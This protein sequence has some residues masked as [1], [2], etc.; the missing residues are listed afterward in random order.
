MNFKSFPLSRKLFFIDATGAVVSAIA[1]GMILPAFQSYIGLPVGTLYQLAVPAVLFALYSGS[2][3][4]RNLQHPG[5]WL[6]GIGL[7]NL[8]YVFYTGYFLFQNQSQVQ[9]LG[10]AYFI[11]ELLIVITLATVEL[12]Q[13]LKK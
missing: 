6:A 13:G 1:L 8:G 12:R 7:L 11:G 3:F 5:P 9:P 2:C 4:L 10:W